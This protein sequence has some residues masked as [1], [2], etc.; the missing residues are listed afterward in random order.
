MSRGFPEEWKVSDCEV[1]A[2]VSLV[3][4]DN[5]KEVLQAAQVHVED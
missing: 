2:F 4:G 1:I 5:N 3:E